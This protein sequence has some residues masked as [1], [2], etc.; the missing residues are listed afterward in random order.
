MEK[1][2]NRRD[3]I[4]SV[5]FQ[6]F[7]QKHYDEVS[8]SDIASGAG[9]TKSLLQHY[10]GQKIQIINVMLTELLQQSFAYMQDFFPSAEDE[11]LFQRI[12]DFNMLFF[13]A[14]ASSARLR[15]FIESSV[16]QS[17]CLDAWIDVICK[18]LREKCGEDSFTPL[19]LRTAMTFAMGGSMHLFLHQDELGISYRRFCAVHIRAILFFLGYPPETVRQIISRTDERIDA[20]DARTFLD[21][22]EARIPWLGLN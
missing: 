4:L 12:S 10:Y 20:V 7:S 19:Q 17:E 9:I 3:Q 18:W 5:A 8:L 2:S 21:W 1:R 14:V 13:K 11:D 6:L 15:R 22:C 16:E